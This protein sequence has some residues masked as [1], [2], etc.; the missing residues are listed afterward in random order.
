MKA[1]LMIKRLAFVLLSVALVSGCNPY[2]CIYETHF[3]ATSP[4]GSGFS[5]YVNFRDYSVD[6]PPAGLAW[7]IAIT[8]APPRLSS[9]K[10]K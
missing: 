5:G 6:N 3:V 9:C 2:A 7:S 10:W 4:G 8:A 1:M